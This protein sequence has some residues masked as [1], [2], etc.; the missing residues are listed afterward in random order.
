MSDLGSASN[1]RPRIGVFLSSLSDM[2]GAI[3]VAVLLANRLCNDFP[4]EI[5]EL[6]GGES[7]AFPLDGRVCVRSLRLDGQARLRR[8]LIEVT[9]PLAACLREDDVDVVLGIG[10]DETAVALRACRRVRVPLVFCDHG[11]LINQLDDKMTTLL[12][13]SCSRFCARTVVLT[14]QSKRDYQ[15]RFKTSAQRIL[16]IPNWIPRCMIEQQQPYDV[17]SKRLLWAGRLD[18]EKGID[19]L[20]AI[21]SRVLPRFPEWS[22]DVFG[23]AV[24]HTGVFDLAHAL[25]GSSVEGRLRLC[26]TVD[27]LYERYHEYA[28]GTLT[29][30]REG[31]PLFLLEGKAAG[32][33]LV[34]FDVDTGPRDIIEQ[35]EDGFLI[36]P[37]DVEA[38]AEKLCLLMEDA[39]LRERMSA[40]AFQTVEAFSEDVLYDCWLD[41]LEQVTGY[42][43]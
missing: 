36:T 38:Y 6:T 43:S 28:V 33:P 29:S 2:G 12:R 4:V 32:L 9:D 16:C 21:A 42:V 24:L 15:Q 3:R 17:T 41:L 40:R 8:K 20:F 14:H 26:G 5:I 7:H 22:W 10:L 34:S 23:E 19:L 11:A 31:L 18:G 37:F 27:N 30:Y 1:M 25:E 39:A 35:G 13:R